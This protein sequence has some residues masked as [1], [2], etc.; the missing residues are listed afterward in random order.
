MFQQL[1]VAVS[2]T[3]WDTASR[4]S[5][6]VRS[7]STG[8]CAVMRV[9]TFNILHGQRVLN[10]FDSAAVAA[11]AATPQ[12]EELH[13]A[14]AGLH[15]DV[16]GLQEVDSHQPRS[17]IVDQT[18]VAAA[19]MAVDHDPGQRRFVPAV[20]GTPGNRGTFSSATDAD[21][22][23]A[24]AGSHPDHGPHYGVAL[25][26]VPHVLSWHRTRF[27]PA[28]LALP[29]LVPGTSRPQVL[30]VPDEPRVAVAAV[31]HTPHGIATVATAHLSF[32]P[33]YNVSQLRRLQRWLRQFPRPLVLMGD[34]NL[35]GG[36][37]EWVTGWPGIVRA[38]TYPTFGPRVRF[39]HIL[40]DGFTE[41]AVAAAKA[42]VEIHRLPVS[43]HCAV[44]AEITW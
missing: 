43:D 28:P 44:S 6:G 41:K 38:P 27:D 9:A 26:S 32:V 24:A 8:Y 42:T 4:T 14:I 31:L 11:A 22:D 39:D 23:R 17:G 25:I 1:S 2:L 33:G 3:A 35:P 15:P 37:P 7:A 19:A 29:L 20:V 36:I 13:A 30:S 16:L 21:A 12:A 5:E 18:L 40:L 34:F 10:G